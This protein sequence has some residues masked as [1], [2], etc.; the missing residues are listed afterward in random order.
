MRTVEAV[1]PRA[2]DEA[3]AEP[4]A[5]TVLHSAASAARTMQA[6]MSAGSA[7]SAAGADMLTVRPAELTHDRLLVQVYCVSAILTAS[8]RTQHS[9]DR[10][11]GFWRSRPEGGA[12]HSE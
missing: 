6:Q 7:G 4:K 9:G 8:P 2:A 11:R 3:Q 12:Q 10:E 1:A 5:C